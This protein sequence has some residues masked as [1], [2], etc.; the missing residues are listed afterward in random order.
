MCVVSLLLVCVVRCESVVAVWCVVG[1]GH[2]CHVT[3]EFGSSLIGLQYLRRLWRI[4]GLIIPGLL[5]AVGGL[6][7]GQG[8]SRS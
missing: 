2:P 1:L 4:S 6:E 3:V 5:W 8:L 7:I